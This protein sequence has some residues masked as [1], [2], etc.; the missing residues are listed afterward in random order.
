MGARDASCRIARLTLDT[1]IGRS[2]I[3]SRQRIV[4]LFLELYDLKRNGG[5][6][7]ERKNYPNR[8][9]GLHEALDR[10]PP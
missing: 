7:N 1:I 8:V 6:V 9:A 5:M 4:I 2:E 3:D 10:S